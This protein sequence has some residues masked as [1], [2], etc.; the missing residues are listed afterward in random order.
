MYS[1][2]LGIAGLV[3]FGLV[4]ITS[5]L[6]AQQS[7]EKEQLEPL[8]SDVGIVG[9]SANLHWHNYYSPLED[10][11]NSN[12]DLKLQFQNIR[13]LSRHV[14]IGY[15]AFANMHI[16]GF[17]EDF[18]IGAGALGPMLRYY[19]FESVRWQPYLQGGALIGLNLALSDPLGANTDEGVRFRTFLRAGL[20]YKV[21]NNFGIFLEAGPTWEYDTG[22]SLDAHALQVDFGIQLFLF[23]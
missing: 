2:L 20:T 3:I 8:R 11:M 19:P 15:K 16:T 21:S 18:G 7:S 9:L 5:P 6:K 4:I 22:L 13:M 12:T 17:F 23:N 14:G 10:E 1:K